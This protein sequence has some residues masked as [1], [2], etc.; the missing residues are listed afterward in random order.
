MLK[1]T[2]QRDSGKMTVKLE[3]KLSGPWV[4][5]LEKCWKEHSPLPSENAAIDLSEVTYVDPEGKRLLARL[6]EEGAD[7]RGT[8][9]VTRYI[10]DEITR[11][12][13]RSASHGG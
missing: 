8:N 9:L 4:G 3:G 12:G 11:A 2:F 10:V 7:L 1:I 5:E 6:I 13:I